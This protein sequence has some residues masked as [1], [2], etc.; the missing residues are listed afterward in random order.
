MIKRIKEAIL[1]FLLIFA[2]FSMV[3]AETLEHVE[4]EVHTALELIN[5]LKGEIEELKAQVGQNTGMV[6]AN[7]SAMSSASKV[8]KKF[9]KLS[10]GGYGELHYNNTET[11]AGAKT[12]KLD[13]HRFVTFI[14]YEFNKKLRFFSEFELE[15]S[16]AGE[17]K[18]GEIELEQAYI[19]YDWSP[20]SSY[21]A[22]LML[23]P[24]G[25]MNENHEPP[26]FYG[27][28]RNTVEAKIIP[29]TWWG[30]GVGA[31]YAVT[32]SMK[33]DV[34]FHEG[35]AMS[36]SS[37]YVRDGR[38]KTAN[39]DA[40]DFAWTARLS[41][42]PGGMPGLKGSI[43]FQHQSDPTAAAD[44]LE[45]GD[46]YG[47]GL[48]YERPGSGLSIRA[49][50]AEWDFDLADQTGSNVTS[51]FDEQ[52]GTYIEIGNK[53][54]DYIGLFGRWE[55][56]EGHSASNEFDQIT[57]GFNWWWDKHAVIKVD[58][59]DHEK[60]AASTSDYDGFNIGVG[61]DF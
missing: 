8:V 32:D 51:G 30:G 39:A 61:Y 37:L 13:F 50:H 60:D 43:W 54:N 18:A 36:A 42:A 40:S 6:E 46:L 53:F 56:V 52:E 10:I 44:D 55:S 14:G 33:V 26:T 9:S 21:K 2:P 57:V 28:E 41:F 49:L 22:G 20:R 34:M 19:E 12:R 11:D 1:V 4:H 48:V 31:T 58:F 47:I 59:V 16:I 27:V 7:A 29:A 15:H 24:V 45:E 25:I 38:Q 5:K 3:S 17:G 35:L 23:I